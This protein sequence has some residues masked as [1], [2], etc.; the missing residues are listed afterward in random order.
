M[1]LEQGPNRIASHRETQA[2]VTQNIVS[3]TYA[4]SKEWIYRLSK[5]ELVTELETLGI[6][7]DGTINDLRRRMSQYTQHPDVFRTP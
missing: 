3:K 2:I 7:T 6:D 1:A 5:S 4:M